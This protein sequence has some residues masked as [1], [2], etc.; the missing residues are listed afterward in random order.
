MKECYRNQEESFKDITDIEKYQSDAREILDSKRDGNKFIVTGKGSNRKN[1]SP[2]AREF[3][4]TR[5]QLGMA[6]V[7]LQ[8]AT[9]T[10]NSKPSKDNSPVISSHD[11]ELLDASRSSYVERLKSLNPINTNKQ[12]QVIGIKSKQLVGNSTFSP[13]RFSYLQGEDIY[14]KGEEEDDWAQ[15]FANIAKESDI[16]PR[17]MM[18]NKKSHERKKS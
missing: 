1:L 14:K 12:L 18:K 11:R 5:R 3:T 13:N 6:S 15:C 16:S 10:R 8:V 9:T 17:Q 4:P 2:N 7:S